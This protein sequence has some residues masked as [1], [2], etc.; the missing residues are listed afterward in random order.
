MLEQQF[1]Q[2]GCTES[3]CAVKLGKLLNMQKMIYGSFMK[4]GTSYFIA[5][6]VI[7]VE[8]GKIEK[9][10]RCNFSSMDGLDRGIKSLVVDL[11]GKSAASSASE[12]TDGGPVTAGHA[13]VIIYAKVPYVD[14][15]IDN[16]PQGTCGSSMTREVK[17]GRH[18]IRIVKDG[19]VSQKIDEDFAEGSVRE[20]SVLLNAGIDPDTTREK[21]DR[22]MHDGWFFFWSGVALTA[23]GGGMIGGSYALA[24]IATNTYNEYKAAITATTAKDLGDRYQTQY[25]FANLLWYAGATAAILGL[26]G[27]GI[28]LYDLIEYN[29]YNDM[30]KRVSPM[31]TSF[32]I[33]P[34]SIAVQLA[35]RF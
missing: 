11:T 23:G 25:T 10:A 22:A 27:C 13:R 34:D 24:G 2:T 26:T 28:A 31:N 4:A 17:A 12:G 33:T 1:Q 35:V 7:D 15:F 9:G 5:I 19:Y 16:I 18:Q 20:F 29:R 21:R 8:T 6:E 3:A 14:V 32:L 30:L